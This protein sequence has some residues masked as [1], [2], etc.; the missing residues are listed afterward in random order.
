M[1]QVCDKK[2]WTTNLGTVLLDT[3][4]RIATGLNQPKT[5]K[6]LYLWAS[7]VAS[8]I[9]VIMARLLWPKKAARSNYKVVD[10]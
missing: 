2:D 7:D 3:L 9:G 6:W 4:V 8:T 10:C 5:A 1:P